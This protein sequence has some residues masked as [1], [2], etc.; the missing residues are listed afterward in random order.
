MT[1]FKAQ[2]DGKLSEII[3]ENF[4]GAAS[5]SLIMKLLRKKDVKINGKRTGKDENVS[6]GDEIC[7]YA[8]VK[9]DRAEKILYEDED[10]LVVYKPKGI[11][12]EDF[13]ELIKQ[14]RENA[15]FITDLTEIR[16]ES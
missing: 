4:N 2:K 8:D 3:S 10:I 5:Y 12:S 15:R 9:D 13:Y 14:E 1:V 11:T 16:T 6:R 7:I